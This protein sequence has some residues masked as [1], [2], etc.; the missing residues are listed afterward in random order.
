[1]GDLL[2]S[3]TPVGGGIGLF[4][5]ALLLLLGFALKRLDKGPTEIQAGYS[6]LVK[7]MQLSNAAY[8]ARTQKA[9]RRA[10]L[11]HGYRVRAEEYAY[12]LESALGVPHRIWAYEDDDQADQDA[13]T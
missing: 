3:I 8:L 10:G 2:P 6:G 12:G 5:S 7:D 4:F 11:E 1:M 13:L 9:E